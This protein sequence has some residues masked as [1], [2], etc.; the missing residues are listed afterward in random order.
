VVFAGVLA[1]VVSPLL[2]GALTEDERS[3]TGD[4]RSLTGDGRS[5]AGGSGSA[6]A[7]AAAAV[8]ASVPTSVVASAMGGAAPAVGAL[9]AGVLA[10]GVLAAG[11][12]V[13][14]SRVGAAAGEGVA[15]FGGT[16]DC[17]PNAPRP[18]AE[19]AR[20]NLSIESW[21][22]GASDGAGALLVAPGG[23]LWAAGGRDGGAACWH[24]G[25]S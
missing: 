24:P 18:V 7:G 10:A 16:L 11:V 9:A 23:V 25:A 1:D 4:E 19:A 21:L 2:G 17:T 13:G 12:L 20:S 15:G 6:L 22:I 8:D 5:F 14:C 3:L